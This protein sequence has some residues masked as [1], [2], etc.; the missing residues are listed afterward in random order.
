MEFLVFFNPHKIKSVNEKTD[1]LLAGNRC[2][3]WYFAKEKV[4]PYIKQYYC[5]GT[6]SPL[7]S[8]LSVADSNTVA[9]PKPL[10]DA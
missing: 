9:E 4:Q 3:F 7:L 2:L 5:M 8:I 1:Y 10:E 6:S